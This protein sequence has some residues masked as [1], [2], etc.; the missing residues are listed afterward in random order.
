MKKII[1]VSIAMYSCGV[2]AGEW[3][4][5]VDT[6]CQV[7]SRTSSTEGKSISIKWSGLCENNK[8]NGKGILQWYVNG[9]LISR[10][11]G[12]L[13]DGYIN[14][15]GVSIWTNGLKYDGE[16]K[17]NVQSGYGERTVTKNGKLTETFKGEFENGDP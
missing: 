12:D 10:Y 13:L 15:K 11:E 6:R 9:K 2:F 5:D 14:G 16:W 3:I 8:A 4:S 7:W 1:Y 17:N